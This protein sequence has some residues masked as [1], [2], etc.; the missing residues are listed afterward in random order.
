LGVSIRVTQM[1]E[2]T[3]ECVVRHRFDSRF[4]AVDHPGKS[5]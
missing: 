5:V 4:G 2:P 3:G 1:G